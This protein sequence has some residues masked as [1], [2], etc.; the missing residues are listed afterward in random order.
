MNF[1]VSFHFSNISLEKTRDLYVGKFDIEKQ[2]LLDELDNLRRARDALEQ[3]RRVHD[4]ELRQLRDRTRVVSDELKNTQDKIRV[5]EQQV[6]IFFSLTNEM[7]DL[8]FSSNN[9]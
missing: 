7:F 5:L 1:V 3:E 6:H 2:Q 8:P 4:Q 9:N